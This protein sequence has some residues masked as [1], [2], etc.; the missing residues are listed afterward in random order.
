MKSE[1]FSSEKMCCYAIKVRKK[2]VKYTVLLYIRL[3]S[4]S[5][6]LSPVLVSQQ[7]GLPVLYRPNLE[8]IRE[9]S[10]SNFGLSKHQIISCILQNMPNE[11][12]FTESEVEQL[13]NLAM[14]YGNNSI[15]KTELINRITNL[16][17]GKFIDLVSA[18]GLISMIAE[19]IDEY[20]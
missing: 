17:G 12:N 9:S 15:D 18:I 19:T 2:S 20:L 7:L 3:I 11:G 13:F 14:E 16:R 8:I 5:G 6:L 10:H 4:V 1:I